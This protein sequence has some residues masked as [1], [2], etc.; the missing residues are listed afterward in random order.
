M[1]GASDTLSNLTQAAQEIVS[2]NSSESALSS[3]N[4]TEGWAIGPDGEFDGDPEEPRFAV[5]V[6]YCILVRVTFCAQLAA[7]FC[8][9]PSASVCFQAVMIGAQSGLFYWK[10]QHKRSYELVW[11]KSILNSW[12]VTFSHT[13]THTHTH[14]H[15]IV[16]FQVTLLGLWLVPVVIS[17]YMIWWKFILVSFD[18][19]TMLYPDSYVTSF[20]NLP[21]QQLPLK[22]C[23]LQVWLG[24]SGITGYMIYACSAKKKIASSVP[25]L[26]GSHTY[27]AQLPPET[28]HHFE[29]HLTFPF[30][31]PSA[32]MHPGVHKQALQTEPTCM[33]QAQAMHLSASWFALPGLAISGRCYNTLVVQVS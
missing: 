4:D 3:F 14:T 31:R 23:A 5:L 19:N 15:H 26:V 2:S 9:I 1:D 18:A 7:I 33:L 27:F 11:H 28:S 13:H 16:F 12:I 24:Y 32:P 29:S 20:V 6:F 21:Y 17:V 25:R 22:E 10:K 8:T 30:P